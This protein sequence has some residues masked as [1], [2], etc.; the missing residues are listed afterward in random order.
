M[1]P[2]EQINEPDMKKLEGF[3]ISLLNNLRKN[4]LFYDILL[5]CESTFKTR[6]ST[7]RLVTKENNKL[8]A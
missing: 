8:Q 3:L 5:Y 1:Y 4:I 6:M 2:K 7:K